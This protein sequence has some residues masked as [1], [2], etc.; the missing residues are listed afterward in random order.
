MKCNLANF[1]RILRFVLG[2]LLTAWAFSGGPTWA[3][4]GI[5]FLAT[6]G[7]GFCVGYAIFKINTLNPKE[8]TNQLSGIY[9]KD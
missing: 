1:D 9:E 8:L 2:T 6:S 7:W 5:Y 4:I 3:L